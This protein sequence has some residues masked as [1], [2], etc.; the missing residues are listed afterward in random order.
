MQRRDGWSRPE[1]VVNALAFVAGATVI[2]RTF[3]LDVPEVFPAG[4]ELGEVI[5]QLGFAYLGAWI[6]H[7]V[8]VEVPRRRQQKRAYRAIGPQILRMSTVG[9][10]I[11]DELC[12]QAKE[13]PPESPTS[14][15]LSPILAKINPSQPSITHMT[16][17]PVRF[18]Q[19]NAI[20]YMQKMTAT[21]TNGKSDVAPLIPYLNDETWPMIHQIDSSTLSGLVRS[22]P[23]AGI[24]P[25]SME[26]FAEPL[27]EFWR[28]CDRLDSSCRDEME[29][30]KLEPVSRAQLRSRL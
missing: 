9:Q 30:H 23:A 2:I 3:L 21:I 8:V 25:T 26:A 12:K 22:M 10:Y 1:R 13:R 11:L 6:F 27:A 17:F 7:K 29:R 24:P 14:E 15:N 19:I 20:E 28:L 18:P 5:Y 16:L 4:A